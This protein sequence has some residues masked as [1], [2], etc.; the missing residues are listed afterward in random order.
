VVLVEEV[1][2][3]THVHRDMNAHMHVHLYACTHVHTLSNLPFRMVLV[4]HTP[5]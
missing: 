4:E 1:G 5:G 2:F 3:G